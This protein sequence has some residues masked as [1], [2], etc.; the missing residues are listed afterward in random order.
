MVQNSTMMTK[1]IS[2]RIPISLLKQLI[3]QNTE[4]TQNTKLMTKLFIE[5][6]DNTK[7]TKFMTK[8]IAKKT[9]SYRKKG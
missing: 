1:L 6:T 4:N 8:R 5:N 9:R 2:P 3:N 7:N